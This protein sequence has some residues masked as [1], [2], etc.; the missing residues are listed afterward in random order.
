MEIISDR[1][2]RRSAG[3]QIPGLHECVLLLCASAR[4]SIS[5]TSFAKAFSEIWKVLR[6]FD[7]VEIR[8]AIEGWMEHR[9]GGGGGD[10]DTGLR[11]VYQVAAEQ[12]TSPCPC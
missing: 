10:P 11:P 8:V 9:M 3:T 6:E 4:F 7:H 12:R 2:V 1:Q 5:F